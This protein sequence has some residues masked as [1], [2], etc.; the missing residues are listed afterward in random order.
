MTHSS[1]STAK[2]NQTTITDAYPCKN[3]NNLRN[4]VGQES[5]RAQLTFTRLND[6]T[7]DLLYPHKK[8]KEK[9]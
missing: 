7:E 5:A 6:A 8:K 1:L 2:Y 9:E 4:Q 3:M